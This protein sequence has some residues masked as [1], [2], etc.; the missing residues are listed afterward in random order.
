MSEN[1]KIEVPT[2]TLAYLAGI[3][4]GDGYVT[5]T[6]STRG[7]REYFAPQVGIS[8]TMR[9]PHDLAA[10]IWGGSVYR[11]LPKNENHRPQFQ[12]QRQGAAAITC[13]AA[14]YP[15]LLLKQEHALLAMELWETVEEARSD[16]S[17]PWFGSAYDPLAD[18]RRMRAEMIDLNQSRVRSRKYAGRL[19]D[20]RTHDEFPE[21]R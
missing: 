19:L 10:S 17:F 11:Y 2:T 5:I 9:A 13:I 4:D 12:W 15:Y 6:H 18:M 3:I 16:D 8:G 21:A 20:G 14:I 7:G 1:S